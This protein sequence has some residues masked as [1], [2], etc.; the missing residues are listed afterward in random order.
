MHGYGSSKLVPSEDK[1]TCRVYLKGG[2]TTAPHCMHRIDNR[3]GTVYDRPVRSAAVK[4]PHPDDPSLVID[5]GG[6]RMSGSV[7]LSAVDEIRCVARAKAGDEEAFALLYQKYERTIYQFVYRMVGNADDASDLTQECF[8]RAY[9][10]LPQTTD[11]LNIGAWLRRIAANVCLDALRRRNRLRWLRLDQLSPWQG[12]AA[13]STGTGD[14]ERALLQTETQ[15]LVERI[16]QRLQPRYRAVLIL[17][18]YEGYS[19]DEIADLL[20]ISRSAAK[21]LLFRAREEFRRLYHDMEAST[22]G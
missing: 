19:I 20:G 17:R 13:R 11:D 6:E 12:S 8:I 14:P 2:E 22:S 15:D 9:K 5:I 1:P 4:S 10:A 21:S 7:A 3:Q 16:L 18:E